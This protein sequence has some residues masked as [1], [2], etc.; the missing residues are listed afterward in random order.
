MDEFI[1]R[2]EEKLPNWN[3]SKTGM[4]LNFRQYT[5]AGEDFSF[6]VDGEMPEEIVEGVKNYYEEF[7]PEEHVKDWIEAQENGVKGVPS[8][9]A[10]VEDSKTLDGELEDLSI[11]IVKIFNE[12]PEK[13]KT[14]P[15]LLE[16]KL[17]KN[18]ENKLE[19]LKNF[20]VEEELVEKYNDAK[21]GSS[22]V[23]DED[24]NCLVFS[25]YHEEDFGGREDYFFGYP[26]Q[27]KEMLQFYLTNADQFQYNEKLS[28]K[29]NNKLIAEYKNDIRTLIE[30]VNTVDKDNI[31]LL[32]LDEKEI[33]T[34]QSRVGRHLNSLVDYFNIFEKQLE[35]ENEAEKEDDDEEEE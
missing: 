7:D 9:F 22:I 24:T 1:K 16:I 5:N 2:L 26:N 11:D 8:L 28:D 30:D 18:V 17:E 4:G 6:D 10:L 32:D 23:I 13:E 21:D 20:V 19:Y 15:R 25:Q 34:N 27:I 35:E 29:E 31:I 12:L 33:E 3:I 14:N